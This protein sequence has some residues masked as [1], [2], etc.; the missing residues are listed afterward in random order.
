MT[1]NYFRYIFLIVLLS[2]TI[3]SFSNTKSIGIPYIR[4]Y[5]N[6]IIQAGAQT[7]M[8]DI[9][10]NGLAYFANNDGMLEFDGLHWRNF[11]L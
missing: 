7:W 1:G 6:T 2:I 4:N 8:I 3:E 10:K 9:S 11:R 5:N